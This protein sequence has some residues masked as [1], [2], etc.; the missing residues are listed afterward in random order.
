MSFKK[1]KI[2]NKKPKRNLSKVEGLLTDKNIEDLNIFDPFSPGSGSQKGVLSYGLSS[3]GYDVRLNNVFKRFRSNRNTVINP[4]NV[5]DDDTFFETIHFG[6]GDKIF[7][8]PNGYLLGSTLEKIT[9]PD[10]VS[11]LCVGKSTYARCGLFINTTPL[12]AGWVG[13]ITIEI[14]NLESVPIQIFPY[15]GIMQVI[16]TASKELPRMT[17]DQRGGKYQ[18]QSHLPVGPK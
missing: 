14:S 2:L 9:L 3:H 16:L 5:R 7:V 1:P 6:K 13:H 12:E 15:E 17:Y 11:G 8:P 18:N 10:N 4:K